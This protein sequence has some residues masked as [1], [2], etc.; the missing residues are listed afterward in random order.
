MKS[1]ET[2]FEE[3]VRAYDIEVPADKVEAE[4]EYILLDMRH[5]AQYDTLATGN[6]HYDLASELA[7]QEEELRDLA[8]LEVKSDLVIK[9]IIQKQNITATPEELQAA[10]HAMAE[11]DHSSLEM[12][13]R[14]FGEDCSGLESDVK[15]QKAM[16]WI[17]EQA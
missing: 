11:R 13:Q 2:L 9:D 7:D 16:D 3:F 14:F 8:L 12:V 6:V 4:Y 5:R 10:G 15:R 17:L 1:N